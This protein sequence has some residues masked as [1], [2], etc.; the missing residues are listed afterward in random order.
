MS[1]TTPAATLSRRPPPPHDWNRSGMSPAWMLV[2]IAALKASFSITVMLIFT[3][4]CEAVYASA[5]ACQS[6]FRRSCFWMCHQ[7]I[8][9]LSPLVAATVAGV[10]ALVAAGAAASVA[11]GAAAFVAA[12]GYLASSLAPAGREERHADK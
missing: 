4:G 6:A 8:S 1:C 2:W 5:I 12:G 9:T 10:A 11:A 3:F 7:S